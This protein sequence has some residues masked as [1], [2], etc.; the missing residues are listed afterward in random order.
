MPEGFEPLWAEIIWVNGTSSFMTFKVT[1]PKPV[2][3]LYS[4]RASIRGTQG[5]DDLERKTE[6]MV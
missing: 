3:D 6:A 4:V 1:V 5:I 2:L